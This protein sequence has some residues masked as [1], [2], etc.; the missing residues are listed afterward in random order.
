MFRMS[1]ITMIKS[2]VGFGLVLSANQSRLGYIIPHGLV[3]P[4]F[5]LNE[6]P[7]VMQPIQAIALRN[8]NFAPPLP[9]LPHVGFPCPAKVMGQGWSEIL[10]LHHRAGRG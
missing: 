9:A 7:N 8:D 6:P 3:P 1:L 5:F 2:I 4:K 10:T